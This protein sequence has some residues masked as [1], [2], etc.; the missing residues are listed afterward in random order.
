[1]AS[2]TTTRSPYDIRVA[3][4]QDTITANSTLDTEAAHALAVRVLQ[5]LNAIPEKVR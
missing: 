1:M 5:T 3:L 2:P 4:V